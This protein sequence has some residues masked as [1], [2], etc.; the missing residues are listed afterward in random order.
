MAPGPGCSPQR[1]AASLASGFKSACFLST[2]YVPGQFFSFLPRLYFILFSP[3]SLV[4][5]SVRPS[6]QLV[7]PKIYS[8][9]IGLLISL[10]FIY[11]WQ[12]YFCSFL[13]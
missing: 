6:S 1:C 11:Q 10:V 8:S 13:T 2:C 5:L 9:W 12:H 4:R 7:F 3:F